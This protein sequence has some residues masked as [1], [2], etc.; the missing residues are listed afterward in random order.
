MFS[1][2]L[3]HAKA[4]CQQVLFRF[5]YF[6][7][8]LFIFNWECCKSF[9]NNV[10]YLT[11]SHVVLTSGMPSLNLIQQELLPPEVQGSR[12]RFEWK[13]EIKLN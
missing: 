11:H 5:S 6:W 4:S 3:V 7:F 2:I 9:S 13:N 1:L 10:S 12:I 8:T